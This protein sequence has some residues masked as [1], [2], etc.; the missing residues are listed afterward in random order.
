MHAV[1][2]LTRAAIVALLGA[3]TVVWH[4]LLAIPGVVGTA[5]TGLPGGRA[6][7]LERPRPMIVLRRRS[8]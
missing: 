2:R 3:G 6:G 4:A 1:R 5:V 8:A 7:M